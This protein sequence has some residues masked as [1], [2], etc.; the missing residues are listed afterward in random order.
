MN[1]T[2]EARWIVSRLVDRFGP[3][4]DRSRSP[5]ETLV[6]TILSQN[7]TDTNRD[8]AYASLRDRFGALD[9]VADANEDEIAE[10]IRI[11]GL[12]QQKAH[13]IREA[14]RRL[15]DEQGAI[16]L[17][18][19]GDLSVEEGLAWLLDLPGI[20]RKTAGIVLLFSFGKAYFP[21][22]THIRRVLTRVGWVRDREEPHRRV[23]SILDP[24]PSLLADLHLQVIRLGRTLCYPKNPTCAECPIVER[25]EEGRRR[26]E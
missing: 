25:C 26:T 18:F 20:G 22:D 14:L 3:L 24:I 4:A 10:T 19:L 12:Q 8:R 2:E 1:R 9:A 13:T 15:R 5:V 23:N 21:I 16:D 7:T 11:G 17:S 6:L